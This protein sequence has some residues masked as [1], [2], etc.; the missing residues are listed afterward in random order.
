MIM[1][2]LFFLYYPEKIREYIR[3]EDDDLPPELSRRLSYLHFERVKENHVHQI[4]HYEIEPSETKR[5]Y[6]FVT[7]RHDSVYDGDTRLDYPIH[8]LEDR[9]ILKVCVPQNNPEKDI[10]VITK[11]SIIPRAYAGTMHNENDN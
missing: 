6:L 4:Y 5:I 11:G 3:F 2:F 8:T 10:K 9:K 7:E 1:G